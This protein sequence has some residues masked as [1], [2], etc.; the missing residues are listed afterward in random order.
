MGEPL[1]FRFREYF[2]DREGTSTS[3]VELAT[4]RSHLS[5]R[6]S[7]MEASKRSLGS[8]TTTQAAAAAAAATAAAAAAAAAGAAAW[9]TSSLGATH[10][11]ARAPW[12]TSS[13][14]A[15]SHRLGGASLPSAPSYVIEPRLPYQ[16]RIEKETGRAYA[17]KVWLSQGLEWRLMR[18]VEQEDATLAE[19]G[20]L[21]ADASRRFVIRAKVTKPGA[22]ELRVYR[23]DGSVAELLDAWMKPCE[24]LC[25]NVRPR[26]PATGKCRAII[27]CE[28][29]VING[30]ML[31]AKVALF[32]YDAYDNQVEIPPGECHLVVISR[33]LGR[34]I[35]RVPL[36]P[37]GGQEQEVELGVIEP[38]SHSHAHAHANADALTV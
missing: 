2:L 21:E 32:G 16:S 1:T 19:S 6:Q 13:S 18:R 33:R 37:D 30:G 5:S 34:M 36:Q 9:S 24:K 12:S 28:P 38:V 23:S 27:L 10:T 4:V 22:Y 14:G 15:S 17:T 8:S 7:L 29:T 3:T 35:A 31:R 25:F 11:H 26:A 20:L